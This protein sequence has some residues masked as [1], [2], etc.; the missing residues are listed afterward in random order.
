VRVP[1]GINQMTVSLRTGTVLGFWGVAPP[2]LGPTG[3]YL[4]TQVLN[5]DLIFN[6]SSNPIPLPFNFNKNGQI[7]FVVDPTTTIA[8]GGAIALEYY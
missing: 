6:P 2:P 3:L 1:G 5:S 7:T 4:P 8:A